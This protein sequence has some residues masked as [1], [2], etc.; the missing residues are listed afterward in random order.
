M[1]IETSSPR[2]HGEY[3]KLNTPKLRFS[4]NMCLQFYYHMYGANMGKL[5]VMVNGNRV[6]TASGDK[7]N[8]WLKAAVDVTLS[9][10]YAVRRFKGQLKALV[11]FVIMSVAVL[12]ERGEIYA[13][14]RP[15]VILK[16]REKTDSLIKHDS[17]HCKTLKDSW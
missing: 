15:G 12:N 13:I 16:I 14:S 9:G 1:Y 4:G 6:F 11:M 3:A 8:L 10:M 5:N 7:G 2:K 17:V